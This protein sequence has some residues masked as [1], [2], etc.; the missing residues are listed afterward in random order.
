MV[1]S[2]RSAA[3]RAATSASSTIDVVE[4]LARLTEDMTESLVVLQHEILLLL[5]EAFGRF[6][7]IYTVVQE[8]ELYIYCIELVQQGAGLQCPSK[9]T[10]HTL[11][12]RKRRTQTFSSRRMFLA[13]TK[14]LRRT[15]R[16]LCNV[17]RAPVTLRAAT[18]P[19][20]LALA[21]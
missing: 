5:P 9:Q 16:R 13:L 21:K 2:E 12:T 19:L 14:W 3:T 10:L 7:A 1:A 8:Q 15:T 20:D 4:R 6:K 18:L 11:L 17:E